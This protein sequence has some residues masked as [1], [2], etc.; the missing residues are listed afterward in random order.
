[1]ENIWE[2]REY[3]EAA[4]R[5]ICKSLGVSR[6]IS[7]LL[8]QRGIDNVEDARYFLQAG[9][10]D[11]S[12]P[13]IMGGMQTAVERIKLALTRREKI[14]IYGDYDVDGVCS[15]VIMKEC[16]ERLGGRVDYY[17]P[18]RFREG[19]GLNG[20]SVNL[21]ADRGC[22]LLITVDCGIS[23]VVETE[24]AQRLGIDVIITDHHTPPALQP[25]ALA[26]INPRNDKVKAIAGLA[27]AGV[28]F[29]LASAL[30]QDLMPAEDVYQWLDLVAL[31]TIA[32]VVPLLYEN[33][34]MTQY[35]LP[36]LSHTK[37]PG[38]KALMAES[39]LE[40]KTIQSWQVGFILA[41]RLNS[42][43]RMDS[44]RISVELLA[45][46]DEPQASR[47]AVRLCQLN[48]ERRQI[49]DVICQEAVAA[50]ESDPGL[51]HKSVLVVGGEGWHQG[52]IGIVAARLAEI[53][54]RPFIVISWEGGM[55]KGSARSVPGFNLYQALEQSRD[56]LIGFGGHRMAAGL[57]IDRSQLPGFQAA[58]Q[59]Y[60]D[61]TLGGPQNYRRLPADMEIE[62][63]DIKP[64]LIKEL[65]GLHPFGEG[66]PE[67]CFVLRAHSLVKPMRVGN[68]RAHL[69][70]KTGRN[71]LDGIMFNR[72]DIDDRAL[73]GCSQDILFELGW[74]D[75]RGKQDIQLKVKDLK[76]TYAN[77]R[78]G[79]NQSTLRL[80]P[81]IKLAVEETQAGRPVIF[82]YPSCR[83]LLKHQAMMEYYFS[84]CNIQVLHGH[85]YQEDKDLGLNRLIKGLGKVFLLT[86]AFLRYYRRRFELPGNLRQVVRMW[87]A[88]SG[89]T[90][91]YLSNYN[92]IQV[93]TW[94][95]STPLLFYR[96][97]EITD[98][99]GN[100]WV[101]ANKSKTVDYW[102]HNFAEISVESGIADMMQ[103]RAVRQ[104][105]AAGNGGIIL[106][107][108][109]H[110][111]GGAYIGSINR[112]ILADPPLGLYE[113]AAFTDYLPV[114][115]EIRV[116]VAFAPSDLGY[117]HRYLERLYPHRDT[118][119]G[120]FKLLSRYRA[121]SSKIK[122]DYITAQIEIDSHH[123][124]NRL[125]ILSALRILADLDLC[126]FEKSGS[127][128]AIYSDSAEK[129]LTH[130]G[131][132][133]YYLEGLAEKKILAYWERELN[134][135]LVW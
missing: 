76:S 3:D 128:M 100:I 12:A 111:A 26:V 13:G 96:S 50:V 66:N 51:E 30:I 110:T 60:A 131:D 123:R 127:I 45:S 58:L 17:I 64:Q 5:E 59:Q 88:S 109:T 78:H 115:T 84:G 82:I 67:P 29:K 124:F 92:H 126:R 4:A 94:E 93:D 99:Q 63:E 70:F 43:G 79:H 56:Y 101:Y 52:V 25:P 73:L 57:T 91:D 77:F 85:L 15:I 125:E 31:A 89:K 106:S 47:L 24:L 61:R 19:Y 32:D 41:P 80:A 16:L 98:L 117:N 104:I 65:E 28:A 133:P 83:S 37:R 48:Q 71:N 87:P 107:D 36:L 9:L 38:L 132:T 62:D 118:V 14:F 2:F 74:N 44:A 116:G 135:A 1:M 42:A 102:N 8:V 49:E 130:I 6:L 55:G 10:E 68:N 34:I 72:S 122:T 129:S 20:E 121:V 40:G 95:Q 35:G 27:G 7:C 119:D 113:M 33:R 81:V 105:Y 134:K 54:N 39:G 18:N 22:Q 23:S 112:M 90:D 103:R 75:F 69:K 120:V 108:G 46:R 86:D 11:L 97:R 114:Q 21:L 53:Y